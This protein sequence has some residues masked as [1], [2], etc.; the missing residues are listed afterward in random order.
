MARVRESA[1]RPRKAAW[2]IRLSPRGVPGP[3]GLKVFAPKQF[4]MVC[5][6]IPLELELNAEAPVPSTFV[7]SVLLIPSSSFKMARAAYLT[8]KQ[9]GIEMNNVF[10][11]LSLQNP[12]HKTPLN[13][14]STQ[15]GGI[16]ELFN[17]A[18]VDFFKPVPPDCMREI[19][20]PNLL[21][22]ETVVAKSRHLS[23]DGFAKHAEVLS[24]LSNEVESCVLRLNRL[25]QISIFGE[26]S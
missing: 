23:M 20:R 9:I 7:P 1:W 15:I 19:V 25:V 18:I 11:K 17:A 10:T 14:S 22:A 3:E 12:H 13:W 4:D 5:S 16:I 21:S 26:V 6:Y 24:C 2:G 8:P